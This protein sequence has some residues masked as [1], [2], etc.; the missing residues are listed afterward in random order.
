M[1]QGVYT[2]VEMDGYRAEIRSANGHIKYVPLNE[3]KLVNVKPTDVAISPR[4]MMEVESVLDHKRARNEKKKYLVKWIGIDEPTWEPLDNLR[5]I[6]KNRMSA[7]EKSYFNNIGKQDV[8]IVHKPSRSR[9]K[10]T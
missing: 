3:L 7:L 5:L 1:E 2:F 8:P 6:N 10:A 9:T 4:E